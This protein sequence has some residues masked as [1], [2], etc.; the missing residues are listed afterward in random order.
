[1]KMVPKSFCHIQQG[2]PPGNQG[3]HAHPKVESPQT[4]AWHVAL[5]KG[6]LMHKEEWK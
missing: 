1:M 6:D 3:N 4:D 5:G 2:K